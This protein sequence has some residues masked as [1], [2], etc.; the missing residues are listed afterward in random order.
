LGEHETARA[1]LEESLAGFRARGSERGVARALHWLGRLDEYAGNYARAGALYEEALPLYRKTGSLSSAAWVLHGI[2]FVACRQ[3]DLG[4]ARAHLEE[5]LCIFREGGY[6][7]GLLRSLERFGVLAAAAAAPGQKECN[8][9]GM[10]RAARLLGAAEGLREATA[11]PLSLPE[12]QGQAQDIE[13]V[14]AALGEE[15]FAAAW[16][17]GGVM[18]LEQAIAYA[19]EQEL[20]P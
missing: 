1:F 15:G 11:M 20:S 2:G 17:E 5:S 19:L 18:T 16:T 13:V 10:L 9:T 14:R 8:A 12:R 4:L 7:A 3:G 6:T